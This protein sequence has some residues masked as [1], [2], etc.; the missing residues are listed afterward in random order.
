ML[1]LSFSLFMFIY[2]D[3]DIFC[4]FLS[5]WYIT[6][7]NSVKSL[8]LSLLIWGRSKL[9]FIPLSNLF[10]WHLFLNSYL[11]SYTVISFYVGICSHKPCTMEYSWCLSIGWISLSWN[12]Y[13]MSKS[14]H[15]PKNEVLGNYE[16]RSNIYFSSS[17]IFPCVIFHCSLMEG[18]HI[19]G[20]KKELRSNRDFCL[21]HYFLNLYIFNWRIIALHCCVSLCCTAM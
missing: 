17:L 19:T 10:K 14:F 6:V 9:L 21:T 8:F 4:I 12:T 2:S 5:R 18:R 15:V 7:K 1:S 16:H 11:E 3:F 13:T 20:K